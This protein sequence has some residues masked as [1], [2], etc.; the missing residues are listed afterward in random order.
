MSLFLGKIHFWLFEKIKWFEGLIK[1]TLALA[2]ANSIDID[3]LVK[4]ANERFGEKL[5]DEPLDKLIDESNIHGWL[6][7]AINSAEGRVCFLHY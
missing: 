7:E 5:K 4:E 1:G 6:Q 3:K 2:K